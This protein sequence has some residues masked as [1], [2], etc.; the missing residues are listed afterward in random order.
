MTKGFARTHKTFTIRLTDWEPE[1]SWTFRAE[2]SSDDDDA[3]VAMQTRVVVGE[4]DYKALRLAH[5]RGED[6]EKII[7]KN[8]SQETV[9]SSR[10]AFIAQMSLSWTGPDFTLPEDYEGEDEKTHELAGQVPP[11]DA[12]WIGLRDGDEIDEVYRALTDHY[13]GRTE[14]EEATFPNEP[15]PLAGRSRSK[16]RG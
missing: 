14:E 13:A 7:A 8:V 15:T 1:S 12:E 16:T 6:V 11:C 9:M 10:K 5:K 2:K 3:V 4:M